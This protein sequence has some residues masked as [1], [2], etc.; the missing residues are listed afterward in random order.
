MVGRN[1][2]NPGLVFFTIVVIGLLGV[3]L[4]SADASNPAPHP[5][6]AAQRGRR[7]CR[8]LTRPSSAAEWAKSGLPGPS[9]PRG[10]AGDRPF[11]PS[12]GVRR[13]ARAVRLRQE[14]LALP[15]RRARRTDRR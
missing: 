3:Y 6:L 11:G 15:D 8:C 14:H 4:R 13:A 2:F 7:V 10:I 12:A 9:G 1:T 5:L